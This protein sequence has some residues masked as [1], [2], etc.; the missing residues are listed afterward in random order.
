MIY[1]LLTRGEWLPLAGITLL[2]AL[3]VLLSRGLSLLLMMLLIALIALQMLRCRL[4]GLLA[5]L[6][7]NRLS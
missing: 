6:G 2:L 4:L 5:Q 3:L 1:T 7:A